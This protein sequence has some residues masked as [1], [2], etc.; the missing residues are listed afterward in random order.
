MSDFIDIDI[1]D[2]MRYLVTKHDLSLFHIYDRFEYPSENLDLKLY[3]T[4]PE[5]PIHSTTSTPGE[6]RS[7]LEQEKYL[8]TICTRSGFGLESFPTHLPYAKI[9]ASYFNKRK[10]R[11]L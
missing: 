6:H 1:P 7:L 9:L 3:F 2:D 10:G 5:N 8:S 11:N 4:D